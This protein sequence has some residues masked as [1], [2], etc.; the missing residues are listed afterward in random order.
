[1]PHSRLAEGRLVQCKGATRPAAAESERSLKVFRSAYSDSRMKRP[2]GILNTPSRRVQ[3][4]PSNALMDMGNLE[5]S[6]R[7]EAA[8]NGRNAARSHGT[9]GKANSNST[10]SRRLK[11]LRTL[12]DLR[13]Y[14]REYMRHWRADRRNRTNDWMKRLRWHYQRKLRSALRSAGMVNAKPSRAPLCGFCH[15]LP[16]ITTVKRL[17]CCEIARGGYVEE[18]VL[19]CGEC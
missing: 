12:E 3:E 8:V 17:K 14:K 11:G 7:G 18:L 10:G 4:H 6:N 9:G 1:M 13:R 2:L 15:L 5:R 16:A 19:Y